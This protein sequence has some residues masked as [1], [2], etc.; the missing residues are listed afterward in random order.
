MTD[1]DRAATVLA[2]ATQV[3]ISC[4]Q[5]PDGDALGSALGFGLAAQ[6]AGKDVS[7][8]FSEPFVVPDNLAFL[9]SDLLV[10]PD[11]FPAEPEVMVVFDTADQSRLG[12]LVPISKAAGTLIVIDHHITNAGFGDINLIDPEAGASALIACRLLDRLGWPMSAEI[13]TCLYVGLVTDTGRFQYSNTS[14]E[15]L[16]TAADLVEAGADPAMIGRQIY[17]SVPFG[18][19]S[20]AAAVTG[21]AVLEPDKDFVWSILYDEDLV[22][23]GLDPSAVPGLIDEI[24]I[25]REAETACLVK[26]V[27]GPV[28]VSLR[29]RTHVD[30][31]AIASAAGGGGHARAA[32][33]TFD[34]SVD[35]A[36]ALVRAAL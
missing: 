10:E 28:E 5:G 25:V 23:A 24:R 7:V 4:H 17:E 15:L 30:V 2:G 20:V 18:F 21:R 13:A 34:G 1:L 26:D 31:G 9:P 8:S 35:E 36:V 27:E 6:G 19:L 12:S 32:G 22:R 16:R 3:A 14:P 11:E 33:F 29:S